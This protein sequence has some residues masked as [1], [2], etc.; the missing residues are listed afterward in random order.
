MVKLLLTDRRV[1]AHDKNDEAL[2]YAFGNSEKK[3]D[4]YYLT[5]Q[6]IKNVKR[7]KNVSFKL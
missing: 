6:Y 5:A 2:K 7:K 4:K 1:D 3:D